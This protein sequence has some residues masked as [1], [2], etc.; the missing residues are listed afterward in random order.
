[1]AWM[2]MTPGTWWACAGVLALGAFVQR[3]TGF[4]LAVIGAPLLLMLEPRL[5]PVILV[6]FGLTVSLLMVRHYWHDVSLDTISVALV[7]R[8]P[9]N[10][11]GIWLL[12]AAPMVILEKFIAVIVLFAVAV[13]LFRF[14]LPVNRATLFIAGIL[15]GIFGTVAAIGGPPIVLL[16]HGFPPDR[17]RG[18]LAA[19]FILTASLTLATLALAGQIHG[20]H[21]LMALSFL[22]A[23]LLG[24][25]LADKVAH[26]L[27]RRL[28]QGCSLALCSL[29]ALGLLLH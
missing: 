15:S 13:T 19:F 14:R 11:L 2:D 21:L 29:A 28:L 26:R 6:L 24:N 12:L 22:P 7:G 9:G 10:A 18:N 25:A 20:W 5:V 4:G 23:V 3:A 8:L 1:M 17:L 27:D 16:M